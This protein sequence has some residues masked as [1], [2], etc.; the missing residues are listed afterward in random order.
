MGDPDWE[1]YLTDEQF[2]ELETHIWSNYSRD[3]ESDGMVLDLL[4]HAI[5]VREEL[6]GMYEDLAGPCI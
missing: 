5:H 3:S 2:A 4:E 1:G 6:K